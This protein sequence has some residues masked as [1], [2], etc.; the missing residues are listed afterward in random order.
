MVTFSRRNGPQTLLSLPLFEDAHAIQTTVHSVVYHLLDGTM[1]PKTAGLLLYAM[2]I[3]SSNLKHMKTET[4]DP[5][6]SVVDPPKLSEIPP[7]EPGEETARMNSHTDR[8]TL[9]PYTPT[10]KDEFYDDIMRQEREL[11]EHPE[12]AGKELFSTD[13]PRNLSAT[14]E[15]LD[16]NWKE[17][18][19]ER[20]EAEAA[21]APVKAPDQAPDQVPDQVP[22][23]DLPPGT[24]QGCAARQRHVT[25][26]RNLVNTPSAEASSQP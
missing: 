5:E 16:G 10:A 19:Q 24:I 23:N 9:F 7:P 18:H 21:K 11:H 25:W 15:S 8:R 3:A 12:D 13:L 4:P 14:I 1:D 6:Q 22:D 20:L 2:Q 17:L 26:L